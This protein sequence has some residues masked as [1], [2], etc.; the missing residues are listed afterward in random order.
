MVDKKRE[1]RPR[2]EQRQISAFDRA[3]DELFHA[4]RHCGVL[5]A[6]QEEQS[7]WM[8]DTV[9]FLKERH[10]EL[11][12]KDL[13]QLKHTGLRFCQPVIPHGAQHT[14]MTTEDAN[15]A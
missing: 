3:R 8:E 15:A 13:D 4:I 5:S 6:D 2:S 10:T 7:A 11:T 12:P 9:A 1:R 14:A